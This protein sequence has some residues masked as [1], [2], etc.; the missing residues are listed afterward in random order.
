M[1]ISRGAI[2]ESKEP[3]ILIGPNIAWDAVSHFQNARLDYFSW[4]HDL[5]KAHII[6]S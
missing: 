1:V 6:L 5:K 2:V 3:S 4:V